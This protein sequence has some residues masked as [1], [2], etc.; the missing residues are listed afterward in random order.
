MKNVRERNLI[1]A[2]DESQRWKHARLGK[3][4]QETILEYDDRYDDAD[5]QTDI[6]SIRPVSPM[7]NEVCPFFPYFFLCALLT[8]R[9]FLAPPQQPWMKQGMS[10]GIGIGMKKSSSSIYSSNSSGK[11]STKSK[12]AS[13]VD[14]WETEHG[15]FSGYLGMKT[16]GRGESWI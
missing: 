1:T 10:M 14:E 6:G 4:S 11:E 16:P 12:A 8:Q 13:V 5:D 9:Q 2:R 3:N 7:K 15:G